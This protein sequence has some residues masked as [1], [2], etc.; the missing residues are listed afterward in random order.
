MKHSLCSYTTTCKNIKHFIHE[1]EVFPE[2][3]TAVINFG[4]SWGH[5]RAHYHK[6]TVC[7]QVFASGEDLEDHKRSSHCVKKGSTNYKCSIC[8]W[9][10][11]SGKALGG[12]KKVHNNVVTK[13]QGCSTENASIVSKSMECM[14]Y[15]E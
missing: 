1:D 14:I 4:A 9:E 7:S 15:H 8:F 2:I 5:M 3:Q 12:H 13:H 6:C 11:G 10:F